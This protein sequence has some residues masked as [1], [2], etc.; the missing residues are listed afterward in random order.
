MTLRDSG[1]IPSDQVIDVHYADFIDNPWTTI[2]GIYRKLGRELRPN[3]EQRMRDFL[4]AHPGDAGHGR[5]TWS[6]TG[7]DAGEV[8]DRVR[9]Y[10]ERYE[11][12]NEQLR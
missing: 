8:R 3:T 9:A 11:V 7:L 12:P 10:Q 4:A 2:G 1:R 5:Y 6:D